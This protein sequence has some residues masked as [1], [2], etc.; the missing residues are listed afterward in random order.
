MDVSPLHTAAE[1]LAAHLS[2]MTSGDL[3]QPTPVPGIDLGALYLHLI[4]QNAVLAAALVNAP[5]PQRQQ[6]DPSVR[7]SL[8]GAANLSGGGFETRYRRTAHILEDAFAAIASAEEVHRIDGVDL[9]ARAI[10]DQQVSDTVIHTYDVASTLGMDYRPPADIAS[11]VL[12]S[13]QESPLP[14]PDAVWNCALRL[15]LRI[16]GPGRVRASR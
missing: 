2:E 13:L 6:S 16:P 11:R 12:T 1:E 15:S 14:D 3:K 7:A 10:Y 4:D 8:P 5:T 9:T